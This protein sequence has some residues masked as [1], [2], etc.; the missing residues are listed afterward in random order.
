VLSAEGHFISPNLRSLVVDELVEGLRNGCY[1]LGIRYSQQQKFTNTISTF[2]REALSMHQQWCVKI[3]LSINTKVS[4]PGS[5]SYVW[6]HAAYPEM[7]LSTQLLSLLSQLIILLL[8]VRRTANFS[9]VKN[10][11]L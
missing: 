11:R 4:A 10:M 6:E 3:Q 9:G 2:F 8:L 7:A 5:I 1:T